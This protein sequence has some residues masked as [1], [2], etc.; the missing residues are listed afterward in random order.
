VLLDKNRHL[1]T[2]VNKTA[3]INTQFR[4]FPMEVVAGVDDTAVEVRESGCTF[5][6]DF[7]EVY[8]NSRLQAEHARLIKLITA[9]KPKKVSVCAHLLDEC[10]CGL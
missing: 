2:V 3:E 8:W 10:S 4:T 6:F 5:K 1:R 7:R 9:T